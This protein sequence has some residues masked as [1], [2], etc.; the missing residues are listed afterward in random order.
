MIDDRRVEIALD[1]LN[2]DPSPVAIA[3]KRSL[4][5][6][7]K[8]KRRYAEAFLAAEGSVEARKAQAELDGDYIKAKDEEAEALGDLQDQRD[9]KNGAEFIIEC[10]RTEQSNIRAAERVR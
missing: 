4:D 5:A 3:L 7:N 9:H 1:Y 6:E 10:W 8:C 2:A